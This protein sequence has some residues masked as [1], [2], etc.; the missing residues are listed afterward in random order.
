MFFVRLRKAVRGFTGIRYPAG[1]LLWVDGSGDG[2]PV[3]A[4]P[5]E[6]LPLSPCEFERVIDD[7]ESVEAAS[8]K[9]RVSGGDL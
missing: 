4:L 8:N 5:C 1:S 7:P 9:L 6:F 3:A 2:Y